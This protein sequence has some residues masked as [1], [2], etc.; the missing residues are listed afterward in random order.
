MV[1][2]CYDQSSSKFENKYS[3]NEIPYNF[4][5]MIGGTLPN[6]ADANNGCISF[7]NASNQT[8]GSITDVTTVYV[9]NID[10]NGNE[11]YF[12]GI[13]S[14]IWYSLQFNK[15]IFVIKNPTNSSRYIEFTITGDNETPI[16]QLQFNITRLNTSFQQTSFSFVEGE[17]L[18]FAVVPP[19][20]T[21]DLLDTNFTNLTNNDVLTY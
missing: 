18:V 4:S 12:S 8:T 2:L 11:L 6:N 7:T 5:L 21:N 3:T 15:S 20:H 17:D 19:M 9:S 1:N 13:L 10:A 14:S 16:G